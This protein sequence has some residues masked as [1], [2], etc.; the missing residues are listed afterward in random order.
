M[1]TKLGFDE[2]LSTALFHVTQ[3][4]INFFSIMGAIVADSYFGLFRTLTVMSLIFAI[5]TGIV[6]ISVIEVLNVPV[7]YFT[8]IGIFIAVIGSGSVRANLTAFGGH[9]FKTPE[10]ADLLKHFFSAQLLFLN[11]GSLLGRITNPI[12]REDVKCFGMSDCYPLAFGLP[13]MAMVAALVILVSGK[14]LYTHKT[15]TDNIFLKFCACICCGIKNFMTRDRKLERKSHWLEYAAVKYD[16]QLIN[17]SKKV[18]KILVI[19]VPIPVY[20]AVYMQQSSRWIFQANQM[21][22][23]LGWFTVKPDQMGSCDLDGTKIFR[24][25]QKEI[26]LLLTVKLFLKNYS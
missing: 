3:F 4:L 24:C 13:S 25:I 2:N 21:N 19:F 12:V 10:Q 1:N 22:L 11:L 16:Q 15:P 26:F 5:G 23:D 6:A 17:D 8:L 18:L 20:W 9:Q 7:V 14:S